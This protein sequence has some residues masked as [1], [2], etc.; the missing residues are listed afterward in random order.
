MSCK[1]G[2]AFAVGPRTFPSNTPT[3]ESKHEQRGALVEFSDFSS[4]PAGMVPARPG[5]LLRR[6][7]ELELLVADLAT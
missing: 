3:D 5:E 6:L 7:E 4:L 1:R 2:E